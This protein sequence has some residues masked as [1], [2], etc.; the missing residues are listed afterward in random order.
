M[1]KKSKSA[2]DSPSSISGRP[3]S[4]FREKGATEVDW[5]RTFHVDT[6]DAFVNGLFALFPNS[7]ENFLRDAGKGAPI[8]DTVLYQIKRHAQPAF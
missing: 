2:G 8:G 7:F 4:T 3:V 5:S 6:G 1:A